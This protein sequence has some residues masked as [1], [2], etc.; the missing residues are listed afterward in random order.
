MLTLAEIYQ[1]RKLKRE[2]AEHFEVT[3]GVINA[4]NEVEEHN[5]GFYAQNETEALLLGERLR[6]RMQ[7]RVN[8]GSNLLDRLGLNFREALSNKWGLIAPWKDPIYKRSLLRGTKLPFL[9]IVN[10]LRTLKNSSES[11]YVWIEKETLNNSEINEHISKCVRDYF[12]CGFIF[13]FTTYFLI[14]NLI[15]GYSDTLYLILACAFSYS[16]GCLHLIKV[17][18][19]HRTLLL[20]KGA[21]NGK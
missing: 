15:N 9:R 1:Q 3:V 4:N 17:T 7:E 19:K 13:I 5:V 21:S 20:W 16:F 12:V 11:K 2:G 6:F 8:E 14:M 18:I 10:D